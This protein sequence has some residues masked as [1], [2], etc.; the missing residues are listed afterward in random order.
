MP[1]WSYYQLMT[2]AGPGSYT[3]SLE[4][5]G[6]VKF[7]RLL[8]SL[9]V[10]IAAGALALAEE[11]APVAGF[12]MAWKFGIGAFLIDDGGRTLYVNTGEFDDRSSCY[13]DCT[14]QWEPVLLGETLDIGSGVLVAQVGAVVREEGTIQITYGG[15]PLY[16]STADARIGDMNGLGTDGSW[17]PVTASGQPVD[18]TGV[19]SLVPANIDALERGFRVGR[20]T[21]LV[22]GEGVALYAHAGD[23]DISAC[24]GDCADNWPPVI[25]AAGLSV[26]SSLDEALVGRAVRDDGTE[27][28]TYGGHP[29]YYYAADTESGSTAGHGEGGVWHLVNAAGELIA[30]P[31]GTEAPAPTAT[32]A[33]PEAPAADIPAETMTLGATVFSSGTTPA[34]SSCHG[35]AGEGGAGPAL[36]GSSALSNSERL[37][38]T[39][40][41]GGHI[42]PA[43]GDQL[44]DDRVAAVLTYVR[45]SWGNGF[46]AITPEEVAS[47]R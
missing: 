2:K 13:G 38:R 27:Q 14:E 31:A 25:P 41:R 12:D 10:C 47:S 3:G 35:A 18:V 11:N 4:V 21:F 6:E 30:L 9:A 34:C 5:Y 39:V 15:Y 16:R 43:F 7:K 1:P 46:G 44:N 20:G 19:V 29:L 22:N 42:M 26:A 33:E 36:A 37:I 8:A 40:L 24:Y 45:N 17:F 23:S 28:L 32:E